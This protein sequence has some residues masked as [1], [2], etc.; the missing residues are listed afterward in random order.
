[1]KANIS[2]A[3]KTPQKRFE[4]LKKNENKKEILSFIST[5]NLKN[6]PK[7]PIIKPTLENSKASGWMRN[8][9]VKHQT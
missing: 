5:F 1:M 9:L 4:K 2:K 6:P 7:L 8:A 3:L